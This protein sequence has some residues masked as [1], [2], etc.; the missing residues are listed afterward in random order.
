MRNYL[1]IL[2][3]LGLS[4]QAEVYAYDTNGYVDQTAWKE[5]TLQDRAVGKD[6][7]ITKET[8]II[9]ERITA[10][11]KV[12]TERI[13]TE[14]KVI[15]E[16]IELPIRQKIIEQPTILNKL[17]RAEPQF[18]YGENEV[19]EKEPVVLP[20]QYNYQTVSKSVQ[21]PGNKVEYFTYLQ[22][23]EHTV[24]QKINI[25]EANVQKKELQ[26]IFKGTDEETKIIKKPVNVPG[27]TIYQQSVIQPVIDKERVRLEVIDGPE[28]SIERAPR[29]LPTKFNETLRVQEET[30]PGAT[31][32]KQYTVKPILTTENLE[33]KFQ[34]QQP[35]FTT[36]P[37]KIN[38][39][40]T[41]NSTEKKTYDRNFQVPVFSDVAVK[42]PVTH[43]VP[44]YID[45][46]I[47]IEMP[48][49][50]QR[51][52]SFDLYVDQRDLNQKPSKKPTDCESCKGGCAGCRGYNRNAGNA[53]LNKYFQ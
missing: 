33:V 37:A 50:H 16:Q 38:T 3:L 48:N 24:Y 9:N 41:N 15:S 6:E 21:V 30:V 7:L 12:L 27:S 18:I 26:P 23:K 46:P 36:A 8:K 19:I 1:T 28:R 22:P 29:V 32:Y 49:P 34:N 47:Y 31:I 51:K 11:P 53:D 39:P 35:V 17:V 5:Y 14:P 10:P 25:N 43:F 45:V 52:D 20:A 4:T 42:V 44:E 2:L 13:T 40:I